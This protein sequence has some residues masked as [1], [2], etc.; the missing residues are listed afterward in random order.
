MNPNTRLHKYESQTQFHQFLYFTVIT[1]STVGYGDIYPITEGGRVLIIVLIILAAYFIPLKTG[2]ILSILKDSNVYSREAYKYNNGIPHII[3]RG[4]INVESLISFCEELFHEDHGKSEKNVVILNKEEPNQEMRLFIH[5]GK[6]EMNLKYL[7]GNPMDENNLE[8]ADITKAKAVF[9]L[10]D[11]YSQIPDI[12]DHNNILLA[13]FIKK[14]LIKKNYLN[15]DSILYLQLIKA[16][17]KIHYLNGLESLCVDNNT[18]Q[19]RIIILEQIKMNLLSKSCLF[20][21]IIPLI[22]NL[23]RSSGYNQKT[24]YL[25][26]NEYL[27]GFE[28]EI[29]RAELN[30]N[31]KNKTFSQI[32]KLIYK[33]YD[34]IVFALEIEFDGKT[35]I[36]LNP[37]NFYI[38][39][40]FEPRNDVKYYIYVICSDKEVANK[41]SKADITYNP[42]EV[43]NDNIE[44]NK[45]EIQIEHTTKFQQYMK[46]KLKDIILLEENSYYNSDN[47]NEDDE[48]FFVK[49]N[50][51]NNIKKNTIY[52][53][54]IVVC[55]THPALYYYLLPLRAKTIG[56]K[57]LKD[58]IIL[59]QNMNKDLWESISKF[60]RIVLIEGSP[61]N[62]ED[63]HK[64]N[65]EYASKVVLLE[66]DFAL[67]N[68]YSSKMIDNERI[69]IYKAIKKCN[70]N[71]QIMTELI[72]E[73]NIDYL[74]PKD[75]LS[76]IDP[77][78]L[79]YSTTSVYSSGEVYINSIIDSLTAQ[80]YY[81]KHIVEI[82]HLILKGENTIG[83]KL[84]KILDEIGL[85][86]SQIFECDV[87]DE[88]INKNFGVLYDYFCEKKLVILGLYRLS[89]VRDNNTGYVFTKPKYQTKITHRDKV[90]A[91]GNDYDM[92]K[93]LK[94][95]KIEKTFMPKTNNI[96]KSEK[97]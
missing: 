22:A 4:N 75:E 42:E 87:P 49:N 90:F 86:A 19:D 76:H 2:E 46:L 70:P 82:I 14:F 88:F 31:F 84:K 48:Y 43:Y 92:K 59:T 79:N 77:A 80:A 55:G 38:Q 15:N 23:V 68:N 7:Q 36:Y 28:Q 67:N 27:E 20:P 24:N 63:L 47:K 97:K 94:K 50:E 17:N 12:I 52:R 73:S 74:L 57:N 11:K 41:I 95:K 62:I 5:A 58:V 25:W 81:N 51:E 1:F 72:F 21:G 83:G 93:F 3:I 60:E 13:L 54:H 9:I 66:T 30:D 56:K 18:N 37:G 44:Q 53:D 34:A 65:I 89:G 40:F 16:K 39:K 8:R 78:E 10:T 69:F 64:A 33:I 35:M 29:Y 71:V 85:K 91:L 26:L 96:I 32:S 45:N 61:L 6:Y